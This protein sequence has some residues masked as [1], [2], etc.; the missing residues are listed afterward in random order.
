MQLSA[1]AIL[2]LIAYFQAQAVVAAPS[3]HHEVRLQTQEF[4]CEASCE[5]GYHACLDIAGTSLAGKTRC[6]LS[7]TKCQVDCTRPLYSHQLTY[8]F[9]HDY[10]NTSPLH[11]R[12]KRMLAQSVLKEDCFEQL[13]EKREK[14]IEKAMQELDDRTMDTL[15]HFKL[16]RKQIE[17]IML[18]ID[19]DGDRKRR[20]DILRNLGTRR[21]AVRELEKQF[22]A[23]DRK[24]Q[25]MAIELRLADIE[26]EELQHIDSPRSE[27]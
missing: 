13:A 5:S 14:I 17:D 2:A 26:E 27:L 11:I 8:K 15:L 18:D 9:A 7:D 3:N 16:G 1:T 19:E 23:V 21:E 4:V 12:C 6:E 20:K 22:A 24:A 10:A 25:E